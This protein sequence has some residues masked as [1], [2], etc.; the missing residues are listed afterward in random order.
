MFTLIYKSFFFM[1]Q[2]SY[3]HTY[4]DRGFNSPGGGGKKNSLGHPRNL[5][6]APDSVILLGEE[7]GR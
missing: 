6:G 4:I 7:G 1:L 3:I 5:K 2:V